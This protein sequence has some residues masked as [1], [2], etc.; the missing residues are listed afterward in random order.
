MLQA[1]AIYRNS[2]AKPSLVLSSIYTV[3]KKD[4]AKRRPVINLRWVN[5][6]I[7]TAHFK[8]TTMRDVKAAVQQGDYLAKLD[9]SDCFWGL[10]VHPRDQRFLSSSGKERCTPSSA[11]PSGSACRRSSSPSCIATWWSTYKH[12]V[13]A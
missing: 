1:K 6:H 8:M 5:S 11:S 4:S 9:L 12:R 3:P 7:N 10:P 13:I 2:E